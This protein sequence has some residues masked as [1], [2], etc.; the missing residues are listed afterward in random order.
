MTDLLARQFIADGFVKIENAVPSDVAQAC[1]ELLWAEIGKDPDDE[2]TWTQPVHWVGDMAQEPFVRAANASVLHE[3]FDA[4]VGPGRWVPRSSLGSFPLRFPH[5]DEPDDAGWHV[6][7]S[8]QPPGANS[9]WLNLHSKERALLMLFL[10][11]TVDEHDAPTRIRVGSHRDV[12][13]L[14]QPFGDRGVSMFRIA[15]EIAAV[16]AHR[17]I[18]LA[19]GVAGDV[20]LCHPFLVHA[21]QP[22][23]GRQPRFMAQPPLYPA[24]PLRLTRDD[25]DFSPVERAILQAIS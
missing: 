3:A 15:A 18:A 19:T 2:A 6:E 22:H 5:P 4:L 25:G 10:F 7:G 23:H 24:K 16:S 20:Y 1:A 14:L 9:Y 12:P 8:Y 11:S 21:A 13:P 17:P